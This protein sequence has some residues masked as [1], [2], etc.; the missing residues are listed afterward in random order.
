MHLDAQFLEILAIEYLPGRTEPHSDCRTPALGRQP[1]AEI[2]QRRHAYAAAHEQGRL[3]AVVRREAV[4]ESRQAV[5]HASRRH[6]AHGLG[7][8]AHD[9]ID[10]RYGR[11]VP[12]AY[13]DRPA[14]KQSVDRYVDELSRP[15]DILRVA[16]KNHAPYGSGQ[17]TILYDRIQSLL[18]HSVQHLLSTRRA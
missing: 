8:L 4:A 15:Y 16:G 2:I 6:A 9:L 17:G 12:I 14:Q 7:A 11:V 5:Q 1:L 3:R 13:R 10:D 18:I